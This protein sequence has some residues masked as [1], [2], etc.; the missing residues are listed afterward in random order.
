MPVNY[1]EFAAKI[2]A[3]YPEYNEVDDLTLSQ[4]MVE[5]Y[6]EYKEQVFFDSVTAP[7]KPT[8]ALT[9]EL[10][11]A[12]AKPIQPIG[13]AL[14][15]KES[16][17]VL[18]GDVRGTAKV[19]DIL[20][21]N[22][23][24]QWAIENQ[25]Q[26]NENNLAGSVDQTMT[27]AI[28]GQTAHAKQTQNNILTG[29]DM[30]ENPIQAK[31]PITG[32]ASVNN[33]QAQ[34]E[35]MTSTFEAPKVDEGAN[36]FDFVE[37]FNQGGANVGKNIFGS[38]EKLY[39]GL[40]NDLPLPG[41]NW[42]Y[43]KAEDAMGYL[44]DYFAGV[45][46]QMI[47]NTDKYNG[48]DFEQLAKEGNYSGVVG[49]IMLNATSS[50]PQSLM[51]MF[52]GGTG[53]ATSALAMQNEAYDQL[54]GK[55]MSEVAKITNSILNSAIQTGTEFM[56]TIPMGKVLTGLAT[57]IGKQETA[58]LM[59]GA[60]KTWMDKLFKRYGVYIAPV[61]EGVEEFVSQV[62]TNTLDYLTGATSTFE[63]FKEAGKS[64]VYGAG[65]GAQFAMAGIPMQA[66]ANQQVKKSYNDADRSITA[67]LSR[68]GFTKEE[69]EEIKNTLLKTAP[70]NR[71]KVIVA[72]A[73]GI[74]GAITKEDGKIK[75]NPEVGRTFD[76]F[77]RSADQ[78]QEVNRK[79]KEQVEANNPTL[80]AQNAVKEFEAN[81]FGKNPKKNIN[82]GS[83][84][85]NYFADKIATVNKEIETLKQN[86]EIYKESLTEEPDNKQFK[87]SLQMFEESLQD[88]EQAKS[89]LEF[90]NQQQAVESEKQTAVEEIETL[91]NPETETIQ[92]VLHK[93]GKTQIHV[94]GDIFFEEKGLV[95]TKLTP[96]M[97]TYTELDENGQVMRHENGAPVRKVIAREHLDK[98]VQEV[99]TEQAKAEAV[100]TIDTAVESQKIDDFTPTEAKDYEYKGEI[101]TIYPDP[102][103]GQLMAQK[104]DIN[105]NEENE[106]YPITNEQYAEISGKELPESIKMI[107]EQQGNDGMPSEVVDD[108]TETA[109]VQYPVNK[110][111]E[112][113][114]DAMTVAQTYQYMVDNYGQEEAVKGLSMQEHSIQAS[115]QANIKAITKEKEA[116]YG[117]LRAAKTMQEQLKLRESNKANITKLTDERTALDTQLAEIRQL[118][119][120]VE[121]R[122][123]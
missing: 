38:L 79:F 14:S 115:V 119:P 43:G 90:L 93:D 63:P 32:D 17:Q 16:K 53:L 123:N 72:L 75:F 19:G 55:D 1:Q 83:K 3:K 35:M 62:G 85:S 98:L 105:D 69:T 6:P 11:P 10:E 94:V 67:M 89:A 66:V 118:L 77:L 71:Q 116:L 20:L 45:E 60:A 46:R 80:K 76:N 24:N 7:S 87:R 37:K 78:L 34:L 39:S 12:L 30:Q 86:V 107:D 2:K 73:Q 40:K 68:S 18:Y 26:R 59:Q 22:T 122:N 113:D 8:Y 49:D 82:Y 33:E 13:S 21:D 15:P 95:D 100:A 84:E 91:S 101:L 29:K 97:V 47:A 41:S 65:G 106:P 56:S 50:L 61:S 31:S 23:A 81:Y 96:E 54:E 121:Q 102:T 9:P 92:T 27:D 64:F 42:Y 4:K 112:I 5:K 44:S 99:P 70:E 25:F 51:I 120:Q 103:T 88:F 58:Q 109:P 52:G 114:F 48:K 36:A 74:D 117:K 57:K 108:M 111:G 104:K 28:A 110:K